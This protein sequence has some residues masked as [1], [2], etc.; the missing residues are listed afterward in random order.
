[1]INITTCQPDSWLSRLALAQSR[2]SGRRVGAVRIGADE[3]A[4]FLADE[5]IVDAADKDLI[6]AMIDAGGRITRADRDVM[7]P[8]EFRRAGLG[9]EKPPDTT[10]LP[11]SVRI[12]FD[13]VPETPNIR[14]ANMLERRGLDADT[15]EFSSPQ[16][17]G[18][19][20]FIAPLLAEG[21][22]IWLNPVGVDDTLPLRAPT[23]GAGLEF[24]DHPLSWPAFT[25]P[26]R[27]VEAWQLVETMRIEGSVN[28]VVFICV[29]DSGFWFDAISTAAGSPEDHML[30][31]LGT[32]LVRWN[33]VT[34]TGGVPTGPGRKQW[35]GT[36][37]ASAAAAAIGNRRGAAGSG[38]SVARVCYF[39]DDRSA[40]S[41]EI[42]MIRCTQWGIPFV[43][44]SGGF[45][46]VD[47]LLGVGAWSRT[48][49]WA[50]DNG[51]MMFA[52][53]GNK[54]IQVDNT[55]KRP[56]TGTPRVLT[57]GA[58]NA[59]GTEATFSNWG[60]SVDVWAPG[61]DIPVVP[62]PDP[63]PDS[64]DGQFAS[65]TSLSTPI[66][67]GV[68]AMMRAVNPA[69]SVDQICHM[70]VNTGWAGEGHVTTGLD[71]YAAVW[72]AMADR[73]AEDALDTVDEQL[74]PDA[75]GRFQPIFNKVINRVGDVDTFLLDV[76]A[77][78]TVVVDLRWYARLA[79]IDLQLENT[80][81]DA[82][83]PEVTLHRA[84]GHTT[85]T[86]LVG[87]GTYRIALRGDGPT[88][89][90]LRGRHTAGRLAPDR[91]EHNN[92]FGTATRLR[93]Q[94]NPRPWQ[95]APLFNV[96]GPGTFALNLHTAA[97]PPATTDQDFFRVDVPANI[98]E[99]YLPQ[100]LI[101]SG[102]PVD[103]TRFDQARTV[104]AQW[105]GARTHKV[106]LPKG[107][108]SYLR[109]SGNI[110]TRYSLWVG[111]GLNPGALRKQ[112]QQELPVVPDWWVVPP[113]HPEWVTHPTELRGIVISEQA[114]ADATLR[115]QSAAI[116]SAESVRL[117]LLSDEG[118]VV[119]VAELA[120]GAASFDVADLKPGPYVLQI[121]S[122]ASR[123]RP[124][125]FTAAPPAPNG[126]ATQAAARSS[127]RI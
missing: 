119:S 93:V 105:H 11:R 5:V 28:P 19:P 127:S 25:G 110:H 44:Y 97:A 125:L 107:Q 95:D 42:T 84:P 65:G 3:P 8:E 37:V 29:C 72:A 27:I 17:T 61:V 60:A 67:A 50:A 96:Y 49:N 10:D 55:F 16:A 80:D 56:A 2:R 4:L 83:T 71:A 81:P 79:T 30:A 53:A 99:L 20:T 63:A 58:T 113:E 85:L 54:G 89:Y 91:F 77:F 82:A 62:V 122:A 52:A 115:F 73:M 101:G 117:E 92:S 24:L 112:W 59:D 118:E 41:A 12:Q 98:G 90:L 88:A 13:Q 126:Y 45:R 86:A 103:V 21:R 23:E 75:D 6:Q 57:V 87:S 78:S 116:T 69:L 121:T 109:V 64:L 120:D 14:L 33:A 43:V 34:D 1:M 39:Y 123:S 48:F 114:I 31:D 102:E 104:T 15:V 66:V 40:D 38:G 106:D 94:T 70:L 35:H 32:G 47:P 51:T 46:S 124:L 108:T 18:L 76:P 68:A 100:I 7:L 111:L 26:S 9:R 74:S 36:L 22:G